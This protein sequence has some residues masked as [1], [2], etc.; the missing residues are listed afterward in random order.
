[1]S[2]QKISSILY[3]EKQIELSGWKVKTSRLTEFEPTIEG[4]FDNT[5]LLRMLATTDG[6]V[7]SLVHGINMTLTLGFFTKNIADMFDIDSEN[8]IDLKDLVKHINKEDFSI[9]LDEND[10]VIGFGSKTK[11]RYVII[12]QLLEFTQEQI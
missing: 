7:S 4:H 8:G 9:M 11:D 10:N 5:I 6:R 3:I 12:S 1:M 2:T